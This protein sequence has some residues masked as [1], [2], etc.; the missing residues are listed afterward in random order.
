M[1]IPVN[2]ECKLHYVTVL[3]N[4]ILYI[5][6]KFAS[7][8][9]KLSKAKVYS[10]A[11]CV[12]HKTSCG[13]LFLHSLNVSHHK[14]TETFGL[15]VN[16]DQAQVFSDSVLDA[17]FSVNLERGK[18]LWGRAIGIEQA[19]IGTTTQVRVKNNSLFTKIL[20]FFNSIFYS[21]FQTLK[22]RAYSKF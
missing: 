3:I 4:H 7:K 2:N 8:L 18:H 20:D 22:F 11:V 5:S 15:M 6:S 14:H 10:I 19:R 13:A 1:A 12:E 17:D 21:Q 16:L 9:F